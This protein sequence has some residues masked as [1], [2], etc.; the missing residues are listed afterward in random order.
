MDGFMK[1]PISIAQMLW[2]H[3]VSRPMNA[4]ITHGKGRKGI[5][6]RQRPV[7]RIAALKMF[8]SWGQK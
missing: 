7:G 5:I 1:T 3:Q 2:N 6:I 4:S 8:L